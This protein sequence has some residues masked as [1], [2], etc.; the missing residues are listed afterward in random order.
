M[1]ATHGYTVPFQLDQGCLKPTTL[2]ILGAVSAMLGLLATTAGKNTLSLQH[3]HS[4]DGLEPTTPGH[5]PSPL[6]MVIIQPPTPHR[7]TKPTP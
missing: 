7:V 4:A 2:D 5:N 1:L 3:I 6:S